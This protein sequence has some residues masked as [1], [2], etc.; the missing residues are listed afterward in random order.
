MFDVAT[1]KESRIGSPRGHT[2]SPDGFY[3]PAT[4]RWVTK[5]LEWNFHR[6]FDADTGNL[7]AEPKSPA[8]LLVAVDLQNQWKSH[9]TSDTEVTIQH[10]DGAMVKVNLPS[11]NSTWRTAP[12]GQ[13]IAA[14]FGQQIIGWNVR[15]GN[16]LFTLEHPV[17]MKDDN[18]SLG[19]AWSPDG[20]KIAS[21]FNKIIRV[22]DVGTGR[23]LRSFDKFPRPLQGPFDTALAWTADGRELWIPMGGEGAR[24]D[25]ETGRVSSPVYYGNGNLLRSFSSSPD[26]EHALMYEDFSWTI[27]ADRDGHRELLAQHL[28][29]N[30]VWHPDAR[31]FIGRSGSH[32]NSYDTRRNQRLG[33]LYPHITDNHWLCVGPEGHYRGSKDVES[34]IVY[35]AQL[36]DGSNQTLTPEE[37][38]KK[39]GW[40]NDP[41]KARLLKL[42]P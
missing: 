24:L 8:G 18:S 5:S 25:I 2:G 35:V 23:L 6:E 15:D 30:P 42:D 21:G 36:E 13:H 40:K 29:W 28:S 12:T 20:Q 4:N 3:I 10:T 7:L 32:V 9:L 39:F 33:K 31:R 14:V 37:F 19:F 11:R 34:Q 26:G 1:G 16:K 38:A 41:A 22:W 17:R 27:L